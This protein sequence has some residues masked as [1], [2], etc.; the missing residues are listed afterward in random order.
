VFFLE[1]LYFYIQFCF[2]LFATINGWITPCFFLRETRSVFH[3]QEHS[4][5]H[6]FR[7]TSLLFF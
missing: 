7:S 1:R 4:S 6:S 2:V 5:F 3:W